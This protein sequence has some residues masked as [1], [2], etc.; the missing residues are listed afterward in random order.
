MDDYVLLEYAHSSLGDVTSQNGI[1]LY[2]A[3]RD[4]A[5][6]TRPEIQV[7]DLWR[8][9]EP[10]DSVELRA[11]ELMRDAAGAIVLLGKD[12]QV[13]S[14]AG[15]MAGLGVP[16]FPI[17]PGLNDHLYTGSLADFQQYLF[18]PMTATDED[19]TKLEANL[20]RWLQ[21]LQAQRVTR[22]AT[23]SLQE[24]RAIEAFSTA[25]YRAF[26]EG[27]TALDK[28]SLLSARIHVDTI[29]L[30]LRAP[31]PSRSIIKE[32]VKVVGTY[33]VGVASGVGTSYLYD[34]LP[35]IH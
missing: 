29:N 35:H 24:L 16:M 1:R 9:F 20:L 23:V 5:K 30:Q 2:V 17:N 31:E 26:E 7:V 8:A 4:V 10:D 33:L 32:A 27:T 6:K 22:R 28:T 15:M 25:F 21:Q 34:L 11:A 18:D 3:C 14:D 19:W 12:L 13:A